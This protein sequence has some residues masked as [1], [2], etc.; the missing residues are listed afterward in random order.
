MEVPADTMMQ[1]GCSEYIHSDNGTEFM[2]QRLR[3][4]FGNLGIIM[5]YIEPGSPW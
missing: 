2:L 4:W 5:T 1:N 3:S